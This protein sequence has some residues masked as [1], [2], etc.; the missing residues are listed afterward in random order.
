MRLRFA[1][2]PSNDLSTHDLFLASVFTRKALAALPNRLIV[3]GGST[4]RRPPDRSSA[5][6]EP[7]RHPKRQRRI[8][9]NSMRLSKS[10]AASSLVPLEHRDSRPRHAVRPSGGRTRSQTGARPR[11]RAPPPD[12]Y[13]GVTGRTPALKS[14]L[15]SAL[16]Q[17]R[18]SSDP[19]SNLI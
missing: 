6:D 12:A 15:P 19:F 17:M 14:L 5:V 11:S 1:T 10:L 16:S 7:K 2:S 3:R 9:E 18:H 4:V 13:G 8:R